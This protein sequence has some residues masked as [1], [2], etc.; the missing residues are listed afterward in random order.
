[1]NTPDDDLHQPA[2]AH[3]K[4][5]DVE[6]LTVPPGDAWWTVTKWYIERGSHRFW[7][8]RGIKPAPYA[9]NAPEWGKKP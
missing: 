4:A 1:V 8:R 2:H 5:A 6:L 3:I 9:F 7:A